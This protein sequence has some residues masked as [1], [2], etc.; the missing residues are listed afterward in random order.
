MKPS[1]LSEIDD[2]SLE[3]TRMSNIR[4][5]SVSRLIDTHVGKATIVRD[6][7]FNDALW[8]HILE[9][10]TPITRFMLVRI[11]T[12]MF[13]ANFSLKTHGDLDVVIG[14]SRAMASRLADDNQIDP[15]TETQ[16]KARTELRTKT[17]AFALLMAPACGLAASIGIYH[18]LTALENGDIDKVTL[19]WVVASIY[20]TF[21]F[22][23]AVLVVP[24]LTLWLAYNTWWF[25]QGSIEAGR[26]FT[27]SVDVGFAVL[28]IVV[29]TWVVFVM[30][31]AH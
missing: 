10:S 15:H 24:I 5:D 23:P 7:F 2:A 8:G 11:S 9:V 27:V 12:N 4:L 29:L 3:H 14:Y 25:E 30:V 28:A 21:G 13:E 26:T 16:L 22:R 31:T 20:N 1:K 17:D 19:W 6:V 18:Y